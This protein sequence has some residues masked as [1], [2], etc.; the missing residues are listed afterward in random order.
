MP[1]PSG[2]MGK[3]LRKVA[4]PVTLGMGLASQLQSDQHRDRFQDEQTEIA[5]T[6]DDETFLELPTRSYTQREDTPEQQ[7]ARRQEEMMKTMRRFTDAG[8]APSFDAIRSEEPDTAQ[9]PNT[10]RETP[11]SPPIEEQDR[12]RSQAF[13]DALTQAQQ[14]RNAAS[15]ASHSDDATQAVSRAQNLRNMWKVVDGAELMAAETGVPLILYYLKLNVSS[16]KTLFS[17]SFPSWIPKATKPEVYAAGCWNTGCCLGCS[18]FLF[19]YVF[20]F[21]LAAAAFGGG[22]EEFKNGIGVL[23]E[24]LF[25]G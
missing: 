1:D 5:P 11:S 22:W 3:K 25:S 13:R 2:M 8:A 10:E 16:L 12:A 18:C 15:T 19:F 14:E 6:R 24:G 17:F 4:A 7:E 9:S 21:V 20:P 23:F